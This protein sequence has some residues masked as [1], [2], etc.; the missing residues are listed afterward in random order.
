MHFQ[1]RAMYLNEVRKKNVFFKHNVF[2]ISA[3][4]SLLFLYMWRTVER[5]RQ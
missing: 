4:N 3:G 1:W 2:A 5:G